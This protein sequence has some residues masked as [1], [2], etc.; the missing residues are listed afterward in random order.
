MFGGFGRS[1]NA[2][3]CFLGGKKENNSGDT[4]I[5]NVFRLHPVGNSSEL[6]TILSSHRSLKWVPNEQLDGESADRRGKWMKSCLSLLPRRSAQ[7]SWPSLLHFYHAQG[8]TLRCTWKSRSL[9][10][11]TAAA[12]ADARL[13]CAPFAVPPGEDSSPAPK[14]MTVPPLPVPRLRNDRGLWCAV[15]F[16]YENAD[17]SMGLAGRVSCPPGRSCQRYTPERQKGPIRVYGTHM[18]NVIN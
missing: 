17:T 1:A 6:E 4:T 13:L 9:V 12:L 15:L 3:V 5:I 18:S 11:F 7:R 2:C 10:F 8:F 14:G 16:E